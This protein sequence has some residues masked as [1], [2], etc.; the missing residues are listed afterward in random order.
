M[1]AD[2]WKPKDP[3]AAGLPLFETPK[4]TA[5]PRLTD[6]ESS[7]QAAKVHHDPLGADGLNRRQRIVLTALEAHEPITAVELEELPQ[8]SEWGPSTVRKRVTELHQRGI[9]ESV[10]MR[11]V[12]SASGRSTK[13]TAFQRAA[14]RPARGS[15]A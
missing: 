8:F 2:H 5:R 1:D 7:R 6:P 12:R 9:I 10:G 3:G 4:E 11:A 15:A 13:A 14:N